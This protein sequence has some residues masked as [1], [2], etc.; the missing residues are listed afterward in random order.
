VRLATDIA[1]GALPKVKPLQASK[2]KPPAPVEIH[3]RQQLELRFNY[4]LGGDTLAEKTTVDTYIFVPKNVG[5]SRANYSK[6]QFYGD[7]TPLVRLDAQPLSLDLLA[8][9]HFPQSPLHGF[10]EG[11]RAFRESPRPPPSLPIVIH[12]K[13]YAH[14][15]A[16]GVRSDLKKLSKR[17]ARIESPVDAERFLRKLAEALDEVRFALRAFRRVRSAYWPFEQMAHQSLADAMRNADEYMSLF[18][19]ERLALSLQAVERRPDKPGGKQAGPGFTAR[20]RLLLGGLATEEVHYRRRFGYLAYSEDLSPSGDYY[21]YRA[22]MLKKA[23]QQALYLDPRA[24]KR[25]TFLRN[26]TA[27]VGAALAAI[28]ALAAQLPQQMSKVSGS[29]KLL[30]FAFAVLA[31]V[32][33]DRIKVLTNEALSKRLR[34]FDH[35]N[36]LT[37]ASFAATGLEMPRVEIRES[38][39][40][41][42]LPDLPPDIADLRQN[43]RTLRSADIALEEIIHHHKVVRVGEGD[44]QR[45]MP[46]GYG[47]LDILRLNVR[48]FLVRL[49]EPIDQVAFFDWRRQGFALARLPKVYH[50]NLVVK[51]KRE[52]RG[53]AIEESHERLRVVLNKEG[54][55]R[56]EI[57]SA[58]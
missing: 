16:R 28:W 10:S 12:V 11:L 34:K 43:V 52:F 19:E 40:F 8:D 5:L 13:L 14:L 49:D 20:C 2:K 23:V 35:V 56:A 50:L 26:A 48:H 55:V 31:Y 33:K 7:V 51:I 53:G 15:F 22:S 47:V 24:V 36:N 6:E 21:T 42:S 18:L 25:D 38:M 3:D 39:R 37:A 46:Q 27:G 32:L 57:V 4:D 9:A 44:E 30:I 54:I 41:L 17:L 58:E 1:A 29:A 45:R